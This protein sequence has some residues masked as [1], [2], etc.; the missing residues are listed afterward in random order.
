MTPFARARLVRLGVGSLISSALAAAPAALAQS[1]AADLAARVDEVFAPWNRTSSPGCAVGVASRGRPVLS[2]AYGMADLEHGIA[3]TPDTVFEAGSVSKQFTAAAVLLLAQEGK[4]SLDDPVRKHLPELPDYGAP[5]TV[6]QMLHHTSGLRDWGAVAAVAGWPRGSRV[7]THAH[8]LDI[9]SRQRALNFT[10]GAEYSYSN[11]GYNLAAILVSR[12]AGKSFADFTREALFE[13]LGMNG[14][15]WRDDYTRVVPRRAIAY[16]VSEDGRAR[17]D[18]PF[19]D[20]HG[21]GGLLTTVGDLLAWNRNFVEATV[22]GRA[23]VDAQLTRARLN[24]GREVGYAAGLGLGRWRGVTEISHSGS[25]AGYRAFLARYPDQDLSV[26]VL[27]NAGSAGA[28]SLARSVAALHLAGAI[29]DAPVDPGI[30]LPPAA[31]AAREGLYRE[32]RSQDV[33]RLVLD[34]AHLRIENGPKLEALTPRSFRVESGRRLEFEDDGNGHARAARLVSEDGDVLRF[35]PV[36]PAQPSLGELAGLAGDYVSEEAEARFTAAVE[37]GSL[38]LR[39]RP[40]KVI[41][42][43]PTYRDAFTSAEMQV[44]FLRDGRGRVSEMSVGRSRLRDL[45]FRRS[46]RER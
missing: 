25:T 22:G 3:N 26:A 33:M 16:D 24:D 5:V 44:R 45:R 27:C 2:R 28:S 10:P 41:V 34:G 13:P 38:V 43:A 36:M 23:F 8:V 20:V 39:Q 30:E 21:N 31:L 37:E 11:T 42:L 40:D 17:M 4:L 18:M 14:T 46:S 1:P 12:L 6:R 19:E 35:E 9:A 7:H 32:L 29:R 15:S